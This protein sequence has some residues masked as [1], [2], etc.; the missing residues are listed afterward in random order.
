M[1]LPTASIWSAGLFVL[2]VL[3]GRSLVAQHVVKEDP[4]APADERQK[5]HLP[6]GFEIQ[7]VASEPDIA[8]PINLAF[9]AAGRLL[10]S[11]TLE[12]PFPAKD[13]PRDAVVRL[14]IDSDT[15]RASKVERLIEGLNIP[16]GV[17]PLADAT[18]VYSIP[19]ILRCT[20]QGREKLVGSFQ[21]VDTHGMNNAFRLW[22]D[23]WVYACHGFRNDSNVEDRQGHKLHLNSGNVYR[24]RPDG[25][26]LEQFTWGQVNPFGMCFDSLGNMYTADCHSRPEYM[27]LRG[28]YYPSFGKPH[29][30][31]GYGPE[32]VHHDHGSTGI[33]G[34]VY[35]DAL[36]FPKQFR[37]T[38]FVGNPVTNRVNHDRLVTHGS[39]FQGIEQPDFVRCDDK[40]FRPVDLQ[41]GPDGALYVA[42]FYNR[43]IGHYEVPLNHPQRDR[44]RGRIWRIVYRG[45]AG[46]EG[47]IAAKLPDLSTLDVAELIKRLGDDNITIRTLAT[48][49][50]VDVYGRKCLDAVRTAVERSDNPRTRAHA[51]W[52]VERVAGLDDALINQLAGDS[53]RLVR[54][55]LMRVLAER[56][57]LTPQ[58]AEMVRRKLRD[59]D[60]FVRRTAADALGQHPSR[61]NVKP[62]LALWA[63]TPGEDANLVH[64]ARMALRDQ[65]AAG[66]V[67]AAVDD[68]VLQ[69]QGNAGRLLDVSLG[70]PSAASARFIL[71]Q[72]P[73]GKFDR[74]RLDTLV[75]HTCRYLD[76]TKLGDALTKLPDVAGE[77]VDAQIV[78]LRAAQRG[79]SERGKPVPEPLTRWAER[80]AQAMIGEANTGR[81]EQG[82]DLAQS[83]RILDLT[84]A[85]SGV[86]HDV[87]ATAALRQKAIA[88]L[89]SFNTDASRD[90][91]V[92]TLAIAPADLAVPV[93]L[94]LAGSKRG[95]EQLL[96][97]IEAGKA[98]PRLLRDGKVLQL[99]K[100]ADIADRDA[101]IERLTA[102]LPEADQRILQLLAS[103]RQGFEKAGPQAD[104]EA[105]QKVFATRCAAC[106]RIGEV[107]AKIGPELHGIGNR[108]L[109]RV[110]ED[111]LDPNRN[112]DGAFRTTIL[113]T[114][115]GQLISGL[116]LR[117]E[118]EV[119][120]LADAAGKEV[121]VPKSKVDAQKTSPLSPM[122]ANFDEVLKEEEFYQLLAFLLAQRQK[123][124]DRGQGAGG[125]D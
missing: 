54:V 8:K 96:A 74:G 2:I 13:N 91:L 106:H 29:D 57:K 28:A 30:G 62:L 68:A 39:T 26:R 69:E 12:Y 38:L 6:Q 14:T 9:D 35:Y 58:Q 45:A 93:A 94:A 72:L 31:L 88:A 89:A 17:L 84:V 22:I 53:T 77:N 46:N 34:I 71:Q 121:R 125:G 104:P 97:T 47:E 63:G 102:S 113:A 64:V 60:A 41:L 73:A 23:G 112:V 50:L 76:E 49:R 32:M 33:A 67:L 99:V 15:G 3:C 109:A 40:W 87:G 92:Q 51:L 59:D 122:P 36:H 116:L 42:D 79:L 118:G 105:G 61:D 75:A 78:V 81:R 43:I 56:E 100:Q 86:A 110:L 1:R 25:S 18:I 37:D 111:V 108:G 103:R 5:F 80:V 20:D 120:V 123:E 65:L 114:T 16:M 85:L 95:A 27:N 117:T 44:H 11:Q 19:D 52:V 10:V 90:A 7:L 101:R 24:F 48:N 66:E 82:I 107:G 124:G 70:V 21:T 115:D 55:H 119:V 83:F 4:L 98:S